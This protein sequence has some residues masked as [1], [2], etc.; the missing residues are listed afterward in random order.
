MTQYAR[1]VDDNQKEIVEALR[2]TNHQVTVMNILPPGFPDLI[3]SRAGY[4]FFIEVKA[5]K[6]GRLTKAQYKFHNDWQGPPIRIVHN[7]DEAF[8][9]I[10]GRY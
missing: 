6:V 3:V 7:I 9:A 10:K 8:E 5:E 4:S 2:R 1:K